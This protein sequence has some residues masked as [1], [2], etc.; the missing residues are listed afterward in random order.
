MPVKADLQPEADAQHSRGAP[1]PAG[2][3]E[4]SDAHAQ[5]GL[6]EDVHMLGTTP[7]EASGI[8]PAA[9]AISQLTSRQQVLP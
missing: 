1:E 6:E 5:T 3:D 7:T 4:A 8:Q 2:L 9:A